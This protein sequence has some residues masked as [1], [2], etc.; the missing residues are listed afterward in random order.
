MWFEAVL[1]PLAAANSW[2]DALSQCGGA[3]TCA[4]LGGAARRHQLSSRRFVLEDMQPLPYARGVCRLAWYTAPPPAFGDS[5]VRCS[6]GSGDA[7][8]QPCSSGFDRVAGTSVCVQRCPDAAA[9]PHHLCPISRT[10]V[11]EDGIC[12]MGA[13][14]PHLC[15][16]QDAFLGEQQWRRREQLR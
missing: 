3:L 14:V 11:R 16:A 15:T 6:G 10:C 7:C 4:G 13:D 2:Q 8:L 5:S 1:R 12:P 9:G